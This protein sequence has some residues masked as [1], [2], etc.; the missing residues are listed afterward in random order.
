MLVQWLNLAET[1]E[2][3]NM[4]ADLA[5]GYCTTCTAV[6]QLCRSLGVYSASL[7]PP[8]MSPT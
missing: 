8:L 3:E 2:T 5:M 7:K 1:E 6:K 4:E